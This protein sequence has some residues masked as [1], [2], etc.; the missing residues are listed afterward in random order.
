MQLTEVSRGVRQRISVCVYR[1]VGK[2][3]NNTSF[4]C[5]ADKFRSGG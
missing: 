4:V 1:C 5:L 3:G 2:L